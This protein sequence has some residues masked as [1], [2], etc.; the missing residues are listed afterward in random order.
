MKCVKKGGLGEKSSPKFENGA[1][2]RAVTER[3]FK[4]KFGYFDRSNGLKISL[5]FSTDLCIVNE[6]LVLADHFLKGRHSKAQS[7][8]FYSSRPSNLDRTLFQR[9]ISTE[10]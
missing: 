6:S 7:L 5:S 10:L 8:R 3:F 4:H 9:A 2:Q 1:A